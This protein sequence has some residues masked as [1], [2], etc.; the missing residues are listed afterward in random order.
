MKTV[1]FRPMI[2]SKELL[3]TGN[4]FV[5]NVPSRNIMHHNSQSDWVRVQNQTQGEKFHNPSRESINFKKDFNKKNLNLALLQNPTVVQN[6][7]IVTNN[8]MT[9]T[10][11]RSKHRNLTSIR[12][13]L[14]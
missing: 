1:D 7:S 4:R 6:P 10:A 12:Q 2:K 9:S 8:S 3:T 11:Y 13:S 5:V 14:P